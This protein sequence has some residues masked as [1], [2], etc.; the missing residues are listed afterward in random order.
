MDHQVDKMM[1][2]KFGFR[3]N[4]LGFSTFLSVLGILISIIGEIVGYVII[5][6][7]SRFSRRGEVVPIGVGVALLILMIPNLIMWIL[8]MIKTR[9]QDIPGIEKIAE[10]YT[11]ISGTLEIMVAITLIIFSIL[12]MCTPYYYRRFGW[13][14]IIY[15]I[16]SA[17]FVILTCQKIH[18]VRVQNNK[19]LGTFLRSRCALFILYMIVFSVWSGLDDR[20]WTAIVSLIVG[21]A[22]FIL[23]IGLIVILHSIRVDRENIGDTENP[24]ENKELL[25]NDTKLL[26]NSEKAVLDV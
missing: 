21:K 19:L 17:I 11:Y 10:I 16:S 25:N 1:L 22:Y 20:N 9:K 13:E 12:D 18:G 14:N 24:E 4:L 6:P 8:L 2:T 3:L 15:I 23:D 5:W 7:E 26:L